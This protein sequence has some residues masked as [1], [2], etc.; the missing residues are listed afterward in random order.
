MDT[1]V[2]TKIVSRIYIVRVSECGNAA[3]MPFMTLEKIGKRN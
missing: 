3:C 2:S 1:I